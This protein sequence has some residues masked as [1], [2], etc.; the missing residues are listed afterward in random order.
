MD[1]GATQQWALGVSDSILTYFII[2]E[3]RNY[4]RTQA[5]ERYRKEKNEKKKK[6][7]SGNEKNRT[8]RANIRDYLLLLLKV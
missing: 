4:K 7:E 8:E 2:F 6:T 5:K 3:T 1:T